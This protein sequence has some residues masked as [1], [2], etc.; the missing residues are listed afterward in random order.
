MVGFTAGGFVSLPGNV[1]S[2][3]AGTAMLPNA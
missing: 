1:T 3:S 2:G